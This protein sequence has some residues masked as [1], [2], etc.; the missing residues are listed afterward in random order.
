VR[1]IPITIWKLKMIGHPSRMASSLN[2]N[3]I[4]N[5][6]QTEK[7]AI[8]MLTKYKN[9]IYFYFATKL[10]WSDKVTAANCSF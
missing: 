4:D 6:K 1:T 9:S 10:Y 8:I 3:Y 7:L 2:I 5:Y